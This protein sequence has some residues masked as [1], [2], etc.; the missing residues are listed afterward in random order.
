MGHMMHH[1][2]ATYLRTGNGSAGFRCTS[3]PRL[4]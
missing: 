1:A 3:V 2:L 4:A